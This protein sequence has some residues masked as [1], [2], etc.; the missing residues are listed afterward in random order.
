MHGDFVEYEI[1]RPPQG[2]KLAEARPLRLI[3]RS[4]EEL[5]MRTHLIQGKITYRI[6]GSLGGLMVRCESNPLAPK[7]GDMHVVQFRDTKIVQV[8][9]YFGYEKDPHIMEEIIF[10]RAH[11]RRI[12][13]EE[14]KNII[15]AEIPKLPPY[16][17]GESAEY[18]HSEKALPSNLK[19]TNI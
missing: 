14:F 15:I 3:K 5:L 11:T 6:I 17:E 2:G 13:P 19:L 9:R 12:W 7:D 18:L 1:T 16:Q 10:F 4:Q 8:L